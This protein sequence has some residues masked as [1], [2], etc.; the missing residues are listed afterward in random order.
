MK[1]LQVVVITLITTGF[2][3]LWILGIDFREFILIVLP[4]FIPHTHARTHTPP[5]QI[6]CVGVSAYVF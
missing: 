1:T 5:T 6:S 3:L 2:N 4:A